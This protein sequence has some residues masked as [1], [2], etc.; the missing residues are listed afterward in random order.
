MTYL[1][2]LSPVSDVKKRTVRVALDGSPASPRLLRAAVRLAAEMEAVLEAV[3]IEDIRLAGL[4]GIPGLPGLAEMPDSP[5][6][7]QFS[8]HSPAP[9]PIAAS[10]I[11]RELR[12]H[13][14]KVERMLVEAAAHA[15]VECSF[16]VVRGQVEEEIRAV[17]ADT[18]LLA[19][20]GTRR[21]VA[22]RTSGVDPGGIVSQRPEPETD[23]RAIL[24]LSC[25]NLALR[26]SLLV[27]LIRE[28]RGHILLVAR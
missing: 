12:I 21:T 9:E 26:D 20:W 17:A 11:E 8:R 13:A 24:V 15:R 5:F 2:R 28:R 3:L 27:E 1:D 7:R 25:E 18:E 10:Q 19:L 22:R 4:A 14:R 23:C 6:A 16:R